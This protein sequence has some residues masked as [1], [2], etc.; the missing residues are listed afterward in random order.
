GVYWLASGDDACSGEDALT[1]GV[2]A[3]PDI[4][5]AVRKAARRFN[6]ARH[7][8]AGRCAH[9]RVRSADP[10]AVTASLSGG[11]SSGAAERPDVWI[12]DSSLW[13]KLVQASG[14]A[15]AAVGV[16]HLGGIASTRSEEHTSELQS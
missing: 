14:G 11:G 4:V 7:E 15:G 16:T 5:P 6:D 10:A 8:I 13:T 1:I 12:P 9:A 2:A 3:A